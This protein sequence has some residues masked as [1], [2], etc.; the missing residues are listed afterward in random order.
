MEIKKEGNNKVFI[1]EAKC[2]LCGTQFTYEDSDAF[3]KKC[4]TSYTGVTHKGV[5]IGR[6]SIDYNYYVR[7]PKCNSLVKTN[8]IKGRCTNIILII[9]S[10]AVILS[11]LIWAFNFIGTH[12]CYHC[13]STNLTKSESYYKPWPHDDYYIDYHCENCGRTWDEK[14]K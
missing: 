4:G 3:S 9:I 14:V 5:H 8:T 2:S 1:G 6:S 13:N 7:C 12:R 10:L 11:L